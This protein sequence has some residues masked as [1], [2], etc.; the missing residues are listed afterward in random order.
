MNNSRRLYPSISTLC[1]FDAVARTLNF[2]DAAKELSLTQ[3][4]VSRQ[5]N[6]LETQLDCVLFIRNTRIISLSPIG[7]EYLSEIAPALTQIRNASLNALSKNNQ[8]SATIALLPTFGTRWLMPRIP[9]FLQKHPDVTLNFTTRIGQ[10]DFRS[11]AIDGA[12]YHGLDDWPGVHLTPLMTEKVIPVASQAFLK[13][14][15][16]TKLQDLVDLPKL[17][18]KSRP[19]DWKHWF[20]SQNLSTNQKSGMV[21]EQFSL[22]TQ[23]CMA[24]VGVALMP[25]FLIEPELLNNKLIAIGESVKNEGAYYF[26]IPEHGIANSVIIDFRD[27]I[28]EETELSCP[29]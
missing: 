22:V 21:F 2:T 24:G 1:A 18:M 15:P 17:H 4:A 16:V 28:L 27:W 9:K 14:H 26:G 10:F 13:D 6:A 25:Q 12:I 5:I 3:S 29:R 20:K 8:R 7:Q 11:D 23:A 19:N